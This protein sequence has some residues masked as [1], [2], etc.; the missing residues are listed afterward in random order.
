MGMAPTLLASHAPLTCTNFILSN[1]ASA[2]KCDIAC[3]LYHTLCTYKQRILLLASG[4]KRFYSIVYGLKHFF[5]CYSDC[6][7]SDWNNVEYR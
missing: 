7:V 3:G 1:F 5:V 2:S 6:D 4:V